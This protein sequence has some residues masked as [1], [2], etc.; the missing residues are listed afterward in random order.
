MYFC[1]IND[2][3]IKFLTPNRTN[4]LCRVVE[5][6]GVVNYVRDAEASN[7]NRTKQ[8]QGVCLDENS[9]LTRTHRAI[10]LDSTCLIRLR[11]RYVRKQC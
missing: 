7:F 4:F 3:G 11:T 9:C 6:A 5:T 1:R 2:R 10:L 8:P